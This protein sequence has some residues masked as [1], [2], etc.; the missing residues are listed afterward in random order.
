MKSDVMPSYVQMGTEEL[1]ALVTEVKET[2]AP[3]K[4]NETKKT[5]GAVDMWNSQ[6]RLRLAAGFRNKWQ[7][8]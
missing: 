6:R 5:F 7:M 8:S 3:A 2:V 1:K 4:E